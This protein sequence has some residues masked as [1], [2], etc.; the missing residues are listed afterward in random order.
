MVETEK[1][2][3]DVSKIDGLAFAMRTLLEKIKGA[4]KLRLPNQTGIKDN[5]I[6]PAIAEQLLDPTK[7]TPLTIL[8]CC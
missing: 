1:V 2:K 7:S 5:K 6:L 4:L 3:A 8:I